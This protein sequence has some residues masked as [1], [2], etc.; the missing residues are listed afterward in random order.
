MTYTDKVVKHSQVV[1]S[2][3]D[4][5]GHQQYL[6]TTHFGLTSQC[7]DY[8]LLAISA[9]HGMSSKHCKQDLMI[10]RALEIPSFVVITKIDACTREALDR[11]REQLTNELQDN[12]HVKVVTV[13]WLFLC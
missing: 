2:F 9:T 3:I 13:S 6:K 5:A 7:P 8:C 1:L 10:C 4:L 11:L 12:H